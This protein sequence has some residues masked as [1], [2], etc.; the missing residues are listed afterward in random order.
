MEVENFHIP[1]RDGGVDGG[2]GL[3]PTFSIRTINK[4]TLL[5]D[6]PSKRASGKKFI[7]RGVVDFKVNNEGLIENIEEW[8]TWDF[9]EGA[10]VSGYHTLP[11]SPK[12]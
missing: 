5:N 1:Q 9:G 8:Y 11:H 2:A 6:L 12:I 7:F 10:D 4:G 3:T